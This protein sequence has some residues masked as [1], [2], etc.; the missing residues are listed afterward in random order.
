M[1]DGRDSGSFWS[2]ILEASNPVGHVAHGVDPDLIG[3]TPLDDADQRGL[4]RGLGLWLLTN[5]VAAQHQPGPGLDGRLED[6]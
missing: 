6:G 3:A 5:L 2:R 1:A 4:H